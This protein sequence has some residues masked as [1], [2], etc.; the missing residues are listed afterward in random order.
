MADPYQKYLNND[1]NFPL[2]DGHM[3]VAWYVDLGSLAVNLYD[4]PNY[5]IGIN[6]LTVDA[7]HEYVVT[8]IKS[9]QFKYNYKTQE[10]YVMNDEGDWS[11][12]RHNGTWA[13]CSVVE[14][15]GEIAFWQAYG[16]SFYH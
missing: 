4:P 9:Y 1:A 7:D 10:M 13:E 15:A 3:G 14:P 11:Y 5:S 12:I 2:C 6:I 16:I 8:E